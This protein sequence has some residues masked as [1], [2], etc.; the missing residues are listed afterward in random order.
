M[1]PQPASQIPSGSDQVCEWDRS[2]RFPQ[3]GPVP[4]LGLAPVSGSALKRR[5]RAGVRACVCVRVCVCVCQTAELNT[6]LKNVHSQQLLQLILL[7]NTD[8]IRL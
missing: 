5:P 3:T 8:V 1:E 4:V 2:G 7:K 6:V